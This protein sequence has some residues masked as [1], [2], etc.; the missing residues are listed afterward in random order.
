MRLYFLHKLSIGI[1]LLS[2]VNASATVFTVTNTANAGTGSFRSAVAA[3]N[4]STSL[5]DT[6]RFNIPTSNGGYNAVTGVFT[7]TISAALPELKKSN[8]FID[9][10]SQTLFTGNTNAASFGTSTSVGTGVDGVVGTADDPVFPAIPGAEIQIWAN[11]SASAV[12]KF[13]VV[14]SGNKIVGIAFKNMRL[15][16]KGNSNGLI[17]YCTFGINAHS[18]SDPGASDLQRIT[19]SAT[20]DEGAIEIYDTTVNLTIQNNLIAYAYQRGIYILDANWNYNMQILENEVAY[21]NRQNNFSGGAIEFAPI[22]RSASSDS[23]SD[24]YRIRKTLIARNLLHDA[25]DPTGAK[26]E[27]GIEVNLKEETTGTVAYGLPSTITLFDSVTIE[28]NSIYENNTGISMSKMGPSTVGNMVR[29]NIINNNNNAPTGSMGRGL[30]LNNRYFLTDGSVNFVNPF[31]VAISKNSFYNNGQLGID[32]RQGDITVPAASAGPVNANDDGDGDAGANTSLN[33]PIIFYSTILAPS[34]ISLS[35][36]CPAGAIVEIF[37]SDNNTAYSPLY[38]TSPTPIPSGYTAP[39]GINGYGEGKVFVYS[40]T[41]GGPDDLLTGNDTYTDDGTGVI[42]N[43]TEARWGVHIPLASF[44]AGF[45]LSWKLTATATDIAGHTSEFGPSPILIVLPLPNQQFSAQKQ[46]GAAKLIVNTENPVGIQKM[47]FQWS[48]NENGNW[49][50]VNEVYCSS[51]K[52]QYTY[53]HTP[54]AKTKN[55]YR[56][57]T[58][59]TNGRVSYSLIKRIDFGDNGK[60]QDINVYPNPSQGRFTLNLPNAI[61]GKALLLQIMD[62]SGRA[63]VTQTGTFNSGDEMNVLLPKGHYILSLTSK[64]TNKI[65]TK[66]ITIQ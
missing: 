4:I 13:V 47:I 21:T 7:I 12:K 33:F 6:I 24:Q 52:K 48:T 28:N 63:V 20:F 50:D 37:A 53:L 56:V 2:S 42:G 36:T 16:L 10:N 35:G 14:G 26:N 32:L 9:G 54:P 41:E 59:E 17:R 38:A 23:T 39:L 43:R 66:K 61:N 18:F 40:F 1:T 62:I 31:Q 65:Y 44:P 60:A 58:V 5:S 45:T 51:Q 57:K 27:C 25:K 34:T 15:V 8:V 64:L 19:N 11:S 30:S 46:D 49:T 29:Y 22:R 3:V 55:Y